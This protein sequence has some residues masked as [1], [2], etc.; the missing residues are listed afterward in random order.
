MDVSYRFCLFSYKFYF[1]CAILFCYSKYSIRDL[2]RLLFSHAEWW[3]P[4]ILTLEPINQIGEKAIGRFLLNWIVWVLQWYFESIFSLPDKKVKSS[5]LL[6][7]SLRGFEKLKVSK[8]LEYNVLNPLAQFACCLIIW[9]WKLI[10]VFPS[11]KPIP[12]S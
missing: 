7:I 9:N 3:L 10:N 1:H 4:W 2:Y 12:F 5:S 8:M 11:W 6:I